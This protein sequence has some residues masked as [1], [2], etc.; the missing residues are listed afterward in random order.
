MGGSGSGNNGDLRYILNMILNDQAVNMTPTQRVIQFDPSITS[1]SIGAPLPMINLFFSESVLINVGS[2]PTI[3][4]DGNGFRPFFFVQGDIALENLNIINGAAIGGTGGTGG[5]GRVTNIGGGGGGGGL[6]AGGAI[7]VD[8]ATVTLT[9]VN[10]S[11]NQ[12]TGGA[13]GAVVGLNLGAGGG[14]GLGGNGGT[15][16][17]SAAGGGG[18]GFSN[19]GN[20]GST[21]DSG[22]GWR[23]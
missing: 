3:V 11:A 1:V 16:F 22:G 4:I 12:S 14:G 15:G 18:G 2:N 9:N 23:W 20:S 6:G 8:K 17:D 21:T 13:G 10:F 5:G 19:G 7:F